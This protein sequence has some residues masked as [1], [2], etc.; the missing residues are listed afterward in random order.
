MSTESKEQKIK[1]E[2]HKILSNTNK[3]RESTKKSIE[4]NP[5]KKIYTNIT[6]YHILNPNL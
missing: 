6:L 1:R 2:L 5:G 3:N 4:K